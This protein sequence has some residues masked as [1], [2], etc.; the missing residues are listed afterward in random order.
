MFL[1][2]SL[3]AAFLALYAI[4]GILGARLDA[5][6]V[7][8][9][10]HL[11][12]GAAVLRHGDFAIYAN[13]P[14]LARALAA[15]PAVLSGATVPPP[16]EPGPT[17]WEP[18]IYGQ[19]YLHA[20][21][22]R[23]L[24]D[25]FLGRL[26]ILALATVGGALLYA[27]AELRYGPAVAVGAVALYALDPNLQAHG[28][29]ATTDAACT[30]FLIATVFTLDCWRRRPAPW[31]LGFAGVALGLCLLSKFTATLA[32]PVLWTLVWGCMLERQTPGVSLIRR[33]VRALT[34]SL[35]RIAGL[36]LVA[37]IVV[38]AGYGFREPVSTLRS[39][40]WTSHTGRTAAMWLPAWLPLPLPRQ[41]LMG[42]DAQKLVLERGEFGCYFGGRWW[43][44]APRHFYLATLGLKLPLPVLA[45]ILFAGV[46]SLARLRRLP[47]DE[48]FCWL[49][50]VTLMTALSL[51][52]SLSGGIRYLLPAMPFL[53]IAAAR[54]LAGFSERDL[55]RPRGGIV[56][57]LGAS[58]LVTTLRTHPAPLSYFNVLAGGSEQGH[59]WLID[60]N[61]DWGQ[62]LGRVPR[63]LE[64][65]RLD[66][67]YLLYFGHVE[68]ELYGIR[69]TLPP[70]QPQRGTYVVSV[71]F[72]LGYA[73]LAPDHGRMVQCVRGA[74]DWL[75]SRTP[76]ERIGTSLWVY[77]VP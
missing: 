57:L 17:G 38:H 68:P 35:P 23:Y 31:I 8:E 5:P 65:G 49:L 77:H 75:R 62:D 20:N 30:T 28:R 71:N 6:T 37:L 39:I 34:R 45:L 46:G 69:Y 2:R 70:L 1:P 56:V 72:A 12:T 50:P 63:Y 48:A 7:D 26:V 76:D 61:L 29:L 73:Y 41:F 55:R 19:R 52:N 66:W 67:V 40:A 11:P 32:F 58:L 21:A 51:F 25:F 42:F 44:Q 4:L 54:P 60:S 59:R 18:W 16:I 27:W 47:L 74:P 3:A 13:N 15:L 14:P 64:E 36:G 43:P 22:S 53:Y 33:S 10:A 9:F 24:I